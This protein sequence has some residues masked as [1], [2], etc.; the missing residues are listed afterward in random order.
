[1]TPASPRPILSW[2]VIGA[3]IV[4]STWIAASSWE[5]VK[6]KPA[7]RVIEVTGSAKRR[8]VSDQIEWSA[9]V[10]TT[11][12]DRTQAYRDLRG[13]VE[14]TLKYLAD[15]QVKSEEIR[16][17]S[18]S[19]EEMFN[20]EYLGVAEE[21]VERQVFSGY[22]ASQTISVRSTDVAR[23]E[24]ISREVT[25]LLER[26]VP[27]ASQ[28]PAYFYTKLGELKI[29]MLAEASKDAR[30][31]GENIVK[32]AGG[33][34]L[35]KLRTADMGIINVNPANATDTSW[36]GNNDTSSLEKD[37]I[38]IIHASFELN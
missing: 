30:V 18:A 12:M 19:I 36:D 4:A 25:Q 22:K 29:A 5:R 21:R 38:T 37:I 33:A 6:M 31:R 7:D 20:T 9:V 26:G 13:Y 11:N 24:R 28:P 27:V 8:I 32:Q 34:E 15:Q 16:A 23:I 35:G 3:A 2:I 17:S 10:E 1:M 14:T